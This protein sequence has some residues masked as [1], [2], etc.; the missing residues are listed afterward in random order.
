MVN[1]MSF[2]FVMFISVIY[3]C[4]SQGKKVN[5]KEVEDLKA[6]IEESKKSNKLIFIDFYAD[7]CGPCRLMDKYVFANEDVA[8]CFNETFINVKV[9]SDKSLG[10]VLGYKYQIP[11]IPAYIILDHK[12][13]VQLKLI[14]VKNPDQMIKICKAKYKV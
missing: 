9:D 3:S 2:C 6:T 1:K 7:W 13:N 11:A 8:N 14:G 4:A 12:K 10:K 5:F